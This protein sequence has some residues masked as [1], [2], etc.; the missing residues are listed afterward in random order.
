MLTVSK[1]MPVKCNIEVYLMSMD[2]LFRNPKILLISLLNKTK[3]NIL[4]NK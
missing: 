1:V 4:L 2:Y 3:Q